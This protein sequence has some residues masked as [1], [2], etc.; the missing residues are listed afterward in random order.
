M[1]WSKK[2]QGFWE[3][4]I[5]APQSLCRWK[6][7]TYQLHILKLD[8]AQ[9]RKRVACTKLHKRFHVDPLSKCYKKTLLARQIRLI[10]EELH[11]KESTSQLCSK[12]LRG[13]SYI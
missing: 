8:E 5:Y 10:E 9:M 1:R 3:G 2:R 13:V 12:M 7:P 11:G 4:G 6:R